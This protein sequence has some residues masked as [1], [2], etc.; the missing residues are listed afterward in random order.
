MSIIPDLSD[1]PELTLANE[2]EYDL[3]IRK[4]KQIQSKNTRRYGIA[5][6]CDFVDLDNTFPIV[7]NL[8]F[9]NYEDYQ[10]DDEDKSKMMWRMVKEF[11]KQLDL[12]T[13][14]IELDELEG[15]E[16]TAKVDIE[17]SDEFRAKNVIKKIT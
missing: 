16:F 6:T 3:F 2:G 11:L 8:W 7:H 1:I 5:L 13:D 4:A 15:K 10:E 9:G 14:G 12:P 17:E